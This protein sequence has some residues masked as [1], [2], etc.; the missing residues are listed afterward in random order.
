M[1]WGKRTRTNACVAL[2]VTLAAWFSQ[3]CRAEQQWELW[4]KYA[5][6]FV[7]PQGRV[8][9]KAAQDRTTSEGQAY[10]MFF[11]LVAADRVRFDKLL[12]WTEENLAGGDMTLRLPAWN[13]GKSP[14]GQWKVLDDHSAS[15]ADLWMAYTLLEAGR[16]WRDDRYAKLG[17]VMASRIAQSEVVLVQGVGTTI[18][19]GPQGFHPEISTY[20]LNPS[21][22]PPFILTRLAKENPQGPWSTV[23]DSLPLLMSQG[24]GHGFAMDWVIAGPGGVRPSL[25]PAQLATGKNEGVP[26]GSYE[27]IRVYLWLGLSDPSAPG[28]R[29]MIAPL[30]GMTNYMRTN[31]APPL[32]VDA[33][34]KVLNADSPVGF[35]AAMVPYLQLLGMKD[36]AKAQMDRLAALRDPATGLYG[37][38]GD[39]YDQNLVMFASGWQ[40]QRFRLDKEGRL[41]LK[42]K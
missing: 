10:A 33:E 19:P 29:E 1:S 7:D 11:A 24:S 28:V 15:D 4:E 5:T 6:K 26:V 42:W 22:L 17:T 9:D 20:V 27:A 30:G 8:I 35:S 40:E 21:Y 38:N 3:G 23:L 14:E 31:L 34:G 36:Q 32:Q 39:Y 41:K 12:K 16:L 37:R 18:L 2:L 25:T 13:W